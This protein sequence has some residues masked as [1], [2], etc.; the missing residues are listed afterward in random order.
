MVTQRAHAARRPRMARLLAT[1]LRVVSRAHVLVYRRTGDA[2]RRRMRRTIPVVAPRPVSGL[3][4]TRPL[5]P[6]SQ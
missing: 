5:A 2:V 3:S 4:Q 1:A 6:L